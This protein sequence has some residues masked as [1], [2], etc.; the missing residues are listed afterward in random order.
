MRSVVAYEEGRADAM[1]ELKCELEEAREDKREAM[2]MCKQAIEVCK[3]AVEGWEAAR[4]ALS[5]SH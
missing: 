4:A 1:E 5:D 2:G 3:D